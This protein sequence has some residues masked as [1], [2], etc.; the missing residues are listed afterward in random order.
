M[1]Q[2]QQRE[3][4]ER[5]SWA[6]AMIFAVG[7]FFIAAL[8]I[9][10]IPGYIFNQMTAASLTGMEQG[11]LALA[12]TCLAG[13][14]VIQVVVMLFDPKPVIPPII[15]SMLGLPVAVAGLALLLWA[16]WTGNQYF[17]NAS[18]SWN[19]LLGGKFL[20]F[21]INV[22]DFVMIGATIMA[23]GISMVFFSVLAAREQRN[24]DRRDAGTTPVIRLLI[25]VGSIM[26]FV[27]LIFYT[28]VS[29]QQLAQMIDPQCPI[30]IDPKHGCAGPIT[31]LFIVDTIFNVFLAV[32]IFCMLGAFALRLHY[33][34][35][36][37][38][39]RTMSGLYIIGINLAQFGVLFLLAWFVMYPLIDW[40]HSWTFI[41][42]GSYLTLCAKITAIPQSC[43]FSQQGGYIMDAVVTGGFF[44]LLMA[45]IAVWKSRRNLVVI[46]GVTIAAVLSVS[47]LLVH[48]SPSEIFIAAL[49]CG[50]G[51][52][53]AAIWTS[54]A[55]REFA[56]V[57]ENSLGCLGM[58][59]IVGTCLLIYL[60]AFAYFSLPVFPNETEGNIPFTPGGGLIV[61]PPGTINAVVVVVIIGL[62]AAI[63]FYFL[64]RNRYKV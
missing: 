14:I 63:Q 61:G 45:S 59:L 26:L 30:G 1:Q 64:T 8:L 5:I 29:E 18:T 53:L 22:I 60:A 6:R 36:P 49:L 39:K 23:I 20:W 46:G 3:Q 48:T 31:G 51:L 58:W 44:T 13:F 32:A 35:R 27:F 34:M 33:L 21:P 19:P 16:A 25:A 10:Q 28:F 54:V 11:A 40:I 42:L 12:A 24:P 62:L 41:G 57:G 38:R 56:V 4:P 50:A 52:A 37:V 47:T 43:S 9:G 17:P 15:F 55:R 7:F 2:T